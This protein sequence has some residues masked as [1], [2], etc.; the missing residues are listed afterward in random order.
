MK[1]AMVWCEKGRAKHGIDEECQ[2]YAIND[3]VV[4]GKSDE[5]IKA[6]VNSY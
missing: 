4:W 5:E 3:T 1:E 2:F 6:N